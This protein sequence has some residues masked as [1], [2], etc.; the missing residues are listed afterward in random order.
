[1]RSVYGAKAAATFSEWRLFA[2]HLWGMG[3]ADQG[4]PKGGA[5]PVLWL[6]HGWPAS[7]LRCKLPRCDRLPRDEERMKGG[8]APITTSVQRYVF[9]VP[10]RGR[11]A[12]RRRSDIELVR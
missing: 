8:L 3:Q 9:N 12:L 4:L 1:M 11:G 5:G 6:G 2:F 7:T 10:A